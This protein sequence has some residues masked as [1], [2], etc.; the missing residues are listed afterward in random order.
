MKKRNG[1]VTNSSSTNFVI[2]NLTGEYLSLREF[3]MENV[4]LINSY[5]DGMAKDGLYM[6]EAVNVGEILEEIDN[7]DIEPYGIFLTDLTEPE[8]D[9]DYLLKNCEPKQGKSERFIW[10][11]IGR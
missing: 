11:R 7:E 8:T 9:T 10:K 1:F 3:F 5:R 4:K 2:V 6:G